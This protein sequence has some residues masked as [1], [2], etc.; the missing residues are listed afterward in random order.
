MDGYDAGNSG[1]EDTGDDEA[2]QA[3]VETDDGHENDNEDLGDTKEIAVFELASDDDL[4]TADAVGKILGI[5]TQVRKYVNFQ[6][7]K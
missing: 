2:T 4:S 3:A 5:I 1:F 6:I 7:S